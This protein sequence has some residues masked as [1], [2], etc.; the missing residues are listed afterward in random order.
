MPHATIVVGDMLNLTDTEGFINWHPKNLELLVRGGSNTQSRW[1][2]CMPISSFK[3]LLDD[4]HIAVS[5]RQAPSSAEA[6]LA[7]ALVG[8]FRAALSHGRDRADKLEAAQL[9]RSAAMGG[10]SRS[11]R[12]RSPSS[13]SS[14]G[15]RL[16]PRDGRPAKK[17]RR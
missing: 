17:R 5:A 10:N 16:G 8:D 13:E 2:G 15:S 11:S 4:L 6:Q 1:K 14:S 3:R 12:S 9:P 7:S